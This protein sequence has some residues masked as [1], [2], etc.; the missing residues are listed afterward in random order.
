MPAKLES[1]LL[2][3]E[4]LIFVQNLIKKINSGRLTTTAKVQSR[5]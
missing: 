1:E 3:R 2:L 5:E 4:S